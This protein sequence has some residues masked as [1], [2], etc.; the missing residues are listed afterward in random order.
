MDH[1]ER[2]AEL[3]ARVASLETALS[4][5]RAA[6]DADRR[7]S[8][9]RRLVAGI[10]LG[11]VTGA[12][13]AG[14]SGGAASP[15][16]ETKRLQIVDADGNLVLAL[17]SDGSAGRLDLWSADGR[18]LARLGGNEHGGDFNLWDRGG[19]AVAAAWATDS[20]GR[21]ATWH[22]ARSTSAI[23]A[24]GGDD[25][26]PSLSLNA[27]EGTFRAQA[28]RRPGVFATS[29][30]GGG[31]ALDVA[32]STGQIS[33][34]GHTGEPTFLARASGEQA[35]RLVLG[36][37]RGPRITLGFAGQDAGLDLNTNRGVI[38][39]GTVGEGVVAAVARPD[40]RDRVQLA[41][42]PAAA[43]SLDI[44]GG[45]QPV[46]RLGQ[47][48][49]QGGAMRLYDASGDTAAAIAAR[50]GAGLLNLFNDRQVAV[51]K[52]GVSPAGRGG[53]IAVHNARGLPVVAAQS[54]EADEGRIRVA[55]A[56]AARARV[57]DPSRR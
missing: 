24:A 39:I 12:G 18:N 29:S 56:D 15:L 40:Q 54:T 2:I 41:A 53:A 22:P 20:G 31:A 17:G 21:L 51:V 35:A 23:L 27:D 34:R 55:D 4:A 43:P 48:P 9:M 47:D 30:A 42:G 45:L 8:R 14:F 37:E 44:L 7:P 13:L 52:A 57:V 10:A 16:V 1:A 49:G 50:D 26:A 19:D 5:S 32:E 33:L 38:R 36:A 11:L 46:A 28:G 6:S 3:T 25:D